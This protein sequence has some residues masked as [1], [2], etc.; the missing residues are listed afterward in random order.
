MVIICVAVMP[1]AKQNQCGYL[2]TSANSTGS[3]CNVTP[4]YV[5]S[6]KKL[7]VKISYDSLRNRAF[8]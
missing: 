4:Q 3:L 6:R 2:S 5:A 7:H 8:A 1:S